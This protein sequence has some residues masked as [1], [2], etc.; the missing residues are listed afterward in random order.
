MYNI[1][2]EFEQKAPENRLHTPGIIKL[3]SKSKGQTKWK[4]VLVQNT[5]KFS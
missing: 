4:E 3:I 1:L 5:Q 2:N